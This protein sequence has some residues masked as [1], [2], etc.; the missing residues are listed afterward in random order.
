MPWENSGL[1]YTCL[2]SLCA[3][4][5]KSL[6]TFCGSHRVPLTVILKNLDAPNYLFSAGGAS[7]PATPNRA[8]RAQAILVMKHQTIMVRPIPSEG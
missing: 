1:L 2:A 8:D 6:M 4:A 7:L 3:R 5:T